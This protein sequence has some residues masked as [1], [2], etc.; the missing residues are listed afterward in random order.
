MAREIEHCIECDK[1]IPYHRE[2][3]YCCK[4]CEKL[5]REREQREDGVITGQDQYDQ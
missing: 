1:Q 5:G 2:S 3:D 4:K